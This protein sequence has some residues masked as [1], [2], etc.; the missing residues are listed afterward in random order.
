MVEDYAL[1]DFHNQL[2]AG[3]GVQGPHFEQ[4]LAEAQ[5]LMQQ[6]QG[7]LQKRLLYFQRYSRTEHPLMVAETRQ[8]AG[9]RHFPAHQME[10]GAL[11]VCTILLEIRSADHYSGM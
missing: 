2:E 1:P 11:P 7:A 9:M 6:N 5:L 8:M 4:Q 10:L 3:Y